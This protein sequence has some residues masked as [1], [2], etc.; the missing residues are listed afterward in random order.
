[1]GTNYHFMIRRPY[2]AHAKRIWTSD[3]FNDPRCD[4]ADRPADKL[5]WTSLLR[6]QYHRVCP[7]CL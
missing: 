1:M 7:A 2:E 4:W 5:I 6:E 3:D